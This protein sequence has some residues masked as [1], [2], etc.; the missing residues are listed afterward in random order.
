MKNTDGILSAFPFQKFKLFEQP[1]APDHWYQ[2]DQVLNTDL[3]A[4][5]RYLYSL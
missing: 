4:P 1:A 2:N 5:F 3:N